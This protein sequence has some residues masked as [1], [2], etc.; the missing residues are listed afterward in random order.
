[1]PQNADNRAAAAAAAAA[2]ARAAE[3]KTAAREAAA[4]AAAARHRA[5][6]LSMSSRRQFAVQKPINSNIEVTAK[7][8]ARTSVVHHQLRLE[9]L[10]RRAAYQQVD[11][12]PEPEPEPEPAVVAWHRC[13]AACGAERG[14]SWGQQHRVLT[15]LY[16]DALGQNRDPTDIML[17]AGAQDTFPLRPVSASQWRF[18]CAALSL[19]YQLT[20]PEQL[21]T[22]LNLVCGGSQCPDWDVI[23]RELSS[24]IDI[25][26]PTISDARSTSEESQPV[27]EN[28]DPGAR[29]LMRRWRSPAVGSETFNLGQGNVGS[30]IGRALPCSSDVCQSTFPVDVRIVNMRQENALVRSHVQRKL[31]QDVERLAAAR[32]ATRESLQR[33]EE[34]VRSLESS[35][36]RLG[37][38]GS[39]ATLAVPP[40]F[41]QLGSERDTLAERRLRSLM[42]QCAMPSTASQAELARVNAL[43]TRQKHQHAVDLVH[44]AQRFLAE[45]KVRS[46]LDSLAEASIVLESL[47]PLG[48]EQD[49]DVRS[50]RAAI[51]ELRRRAEQLSALQCE[52]MHGDAALHSFQPR[53]NNHNLGTHVAEDTHGLTEARKHYDASLRA[54]RL[55]GDLNRSPERK[56]VQRVSA[57]VKIEIV[58]TPVCPISV[59]LAK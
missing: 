47:Q 34:A 24:S 14:G 31:E 22:E 19:K 30:D 10:R 38:P 52:E 58:R 5:N 39:E 50:T 54:L 56:A 15:R 13:M 37:D 4:A 1:M 59:N 41:D 2:A 3:A 26:I 21:E 43:W 11:S 48:T 55:L 20:D 44:D 42:R 8:E 35:L 18:L 16:R 51:A 32:A 29:T 28:P 17:D 45:E 49:H 53:D 33:R 46:S 27:R 23:K 25:P 40:K 36:Q 6:V 57:L 7:L 12:A 9:D